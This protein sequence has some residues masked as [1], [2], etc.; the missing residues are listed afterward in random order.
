MTLELHHKVREDGQ[1]VFTH[2]LIRPHGKASFI[3]L[4]KDQFTHEALK[5]WWEAVKREYCTLGDYIDNSR[6]HYY[7]EDILVCAS[8]NTGLEVDFLKAVREVERR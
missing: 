7:V 2:K 6:Y 3:L 5:P 1:W 4:A 8:E